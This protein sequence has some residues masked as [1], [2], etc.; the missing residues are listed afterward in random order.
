MSYSAHPLKPAVNCSNPQAYA[1]G[2]VSPTS[3]VASERIPGQKRQLDAFSAADL[4]K[5]MANYAWSPITWAD[6]HRLASNMLLANWVAI[7]IDDGGGRSPSLADIRGMV[8][9]YCHVIGTTKSHGLEK[10]GI[11]CDRYRVAIA[12]DGFCEECAVYKRICNHFIERFNADRACSDAGRFFWPCTNI[13][14]MQEYG[15]RFDF[16][17]FLAEPAVPKPPAA[18][19][20]QASGSG[21]S[22]ERRKER[23]EAFRSTGAFTEGTRNEAI[24]RHACDLYFDRIPLANAIAEILSLTSLPPSEGVATVSSAYKNKGL[25]R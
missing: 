5:V 2:W 25:R 18:E 22:Y 3:A 12:L 6:G 1:R 21:L 19:I 8:S 13:I 4:A 23:I 10:N 9:A 14:S 7:D 16:A 15:D 24:Y 11:T 17:P 20:L